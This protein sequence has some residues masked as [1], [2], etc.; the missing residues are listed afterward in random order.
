[1]WEA[2]RVARV[3]SLFREEEDGGVDWLSD[4][5]KI[6]VGS[7]V[8]VWVPHVDGQGFWRHEAVCL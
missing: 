7:G 5:P 6:R 8:D 1:M 3:F 4:L 2:G